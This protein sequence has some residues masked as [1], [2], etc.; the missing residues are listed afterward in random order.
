MNSPVAHTPL[1][2]DR[3]PL[4]DHPCVSVIVPAC[5][6]AVYLEEALQSVMDQGHEA[7][8]I[9]VI[10]DGSSD[11]TRQVA[12]RFDGPVRLLETARASS[13]AG[14]SRNVGLREAKG[15]LIAYLDGDD[16]WL[17]GKLQAQIR[18]LRNHPESAMVASNFIRWYP[19]DS[20]QWSSPNRHA[21]ATQAQDSDA[22]D[23]ERSGWIYHRLLLDTMVWTGTVLMRRE[24]ADMVGE[25]REDL[26][27]AQDYD[28]WIRGSRLTPILTL[29]RPY[30]L[31]RRHAESATRRWAPVNYALMVLESA[32]ARWGR[33]GPDGSAITPEELRHRRFRL[34]FAM[35]YNLFWNGQK[36]AA[37]PSFIGAWRARPGHVRTALYAI[38][39]S[40]VR[41]GRFLRPG[42]GRS[43]STTGASR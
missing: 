43:D 25:F 34:H 5:N 42:A 14:A 39:A 10:D 4:T 12:A 31:Y 16:V 20:G 8:E 26:R 17:P 35:G 21:A 19:D 38:L 29:A 3:P 7:I 15:E 9:L 41:S 6:C 28:Y 27:L 18:C 1:T 37:A 30:A 22:L 33:V 23:P 36:A 24:L 2:S 13:G 40:G 32:I 11:H